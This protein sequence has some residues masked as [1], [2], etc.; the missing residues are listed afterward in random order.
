MGKFGVGQGLSRV[1]DLRLLTGQGQYS[2]DIRLQGEVHGIVVRSPYAHARIAGVDLA[3]AKASP[4]V[5]GVYTSADLDAD[6]IG[7]IP[8]L[9]PMTGK[10]G[11]GTV[12]PGHPVLAR[13]RVSHV[14]DPTL[15]ALEQII[16]ASC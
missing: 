1:E 14:G 6:G 10:N 16:A 15:R 13:E 11:S 2:D 4:G 12:Q 3:E 7:D 5:L 9:A 8:C